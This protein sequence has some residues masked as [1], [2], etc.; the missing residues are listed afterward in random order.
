VSRRS[1]PGQSQLLDLAQARAGD[2]KL[3]RNEIDLAAI[4]EA[5]VAD[6]QLSAKRDDI[7]LVIE[8]HRCGRWDRDRIAQVVDNLV[9]N[10]AS[11]RGA[12]ASR[13]A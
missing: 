8:A 7:Q 4:A 2:W 1:L 5:V 6:A 13:H 3:D 11:D 9:T 10:A 12:I